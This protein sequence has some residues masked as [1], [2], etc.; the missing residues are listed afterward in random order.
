MGN[1]II[2]DPHQVDWL[3]WRP[4]LID[5][6]DQALGGQSADRSLKKIKRIVWHYTGVKRSLRRK[7]WN[8]ERFWSQDRGWDRG[9]YH[10]YIDSDGVL[11]WNYNW[12]R[13]TWGVADCNDFCIHISVE[14]GSA[15]DY[16]RTQLET[17]EWI[18]LVLMKSLGLDASA[19][20]GHWEVN[21]NTLCPGYSFEQMEAFRRSLRKTM[22]EIERG[23]SY[24]VEEGFLK[25]AGKMYRVEEVEL[26]T[27]FSNN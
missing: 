27:K 15:N 12:E 8:H 17:R 11:Y 16:S 2:T 5:R 18:T 24:P 6:R 21:N 19:V 20:Q 1:V 25:L 14:A 26:N 13:M 7:I 10:Y 23:N 9:G 22:K 4:K 3:S